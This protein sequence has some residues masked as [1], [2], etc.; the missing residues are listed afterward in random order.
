MGGG[1]G[2]G[3]TRWPLR[4]NQSG[5]LCLIF[6]LS[7]PGFKTPFYPYSIR[8]VYH[9]FLKNMRLCG[10]FPLQLSIQHYKSQ[11]NAMQ[12]IRTLAQMFSALMLLGP[13][14]GGLSAGICPRGTRKVPGRNSTFP[15]N[16][17]TGDQSLHINVKH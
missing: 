4:S 17:H 5:G 14:C 3:G 11:I 2:G 16:F 6:P 9:F 7:S 13:F 8:L 10:Y 12:Y 15:E 1:G